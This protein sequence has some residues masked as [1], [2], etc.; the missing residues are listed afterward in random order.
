MTF[1]ALFREK[2]DICEQIQGGTFRLGLGGT[3]SL[4]LGGTFRL[5]LGGTFRLGL[6]GTFSLGLGGTFSL[7]LGAEKVSGATVDA[8]ETC[9]SHFPFLM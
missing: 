7:G 4:G 1:E 5:G 6:G 3:F 2:F 9:L 8:T